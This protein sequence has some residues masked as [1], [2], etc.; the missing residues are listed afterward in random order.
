[1]N[2]AIRRYCSGGSSL[3]CVLVGSLFQCVR[4][5]RILGKSRL[6]IRDD[7]DIFCAVSDSISSI[8]LSYVRY[9]QVLKCFRSKT[10]RQVSGG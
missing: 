1:M 10:A 4:E 7:F 8:S 9:N 6:T 3:L 2:S 5:V